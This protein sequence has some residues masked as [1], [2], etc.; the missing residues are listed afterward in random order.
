MLNNGYKSIAEYA[1]RKRLAESGI[2]MKHFTLKMEG[3][4]GTL[5]DENGDSITLVYDNTQK[6]VY[7]KI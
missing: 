4:E 1:I 6:L 3:R 7:E 5:T 2:I